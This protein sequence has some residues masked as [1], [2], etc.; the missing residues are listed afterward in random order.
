M[1][2]LLIIACITVS[3]PVFAS[4]E[5]NTF[6][7]NGREIEVSDELLEKIRSRIN[8]EDVEIITSTLMDKDDVRWALDYISLGELI[9]SKGC[10]SLKLLNT[11]KFDSKVD[12]D[13]YGSHIVPGVFDYVWEVKVCEKQHNYRV[14]NEKGDSSFTVY[15]LEL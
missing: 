15:P 3:L 13:K 10:E 7:L 4:R 2:L 9:Y 14:V 11:R 12:V 8:A 1:K 5:S 6:N